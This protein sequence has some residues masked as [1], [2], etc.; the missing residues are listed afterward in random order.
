MRNILKTREKYI[1]FTQLVYFL[2]EVCLLFNFWKIKSTIM[3]KKYNCEFYH[4]KLK[5][6]NTSLKKYTNWAQLTEQNWYNFLSFWE[7]ER[8]KKPNIS[9]IWVFLV[10]QN[11]HSISTQ[12][13][14]SCVPKK[15]STWLK[16]YCPTLYIL[17]F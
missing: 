5:S 12:R 11:A 8:R 4:P 3:S 17:C 1:S 6:K 10:E 15:K 13:K 16:S 2:M 9:H 7:N 14:E